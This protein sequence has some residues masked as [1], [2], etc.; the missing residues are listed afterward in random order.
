MPASS[1]IKVAISGL[2]LAPPADPTLERGMGCSMGPETL[3]VKVVN[4]INGANTLAKGLV[5]PCLMCLRTVSGT[6]C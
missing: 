5:L 2:A 4:R 6:M 3:D 1:Q